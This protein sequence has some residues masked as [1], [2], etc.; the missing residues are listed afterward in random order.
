MRTLLFVPADRPD[1]FEKALAS[2]ADA[3]IVDLED[4]V[5]PEAKAF[6]R[7]ELARWLHPGRRVLVRI[8]APG[9]DGF[10]ADL[11]ILK[12]PGVRGVVLP[13]AEHARDV[14][15]VAAS[16]AGVVLPL[17]ET[18]LGMRN[19][20]TIASIRGVDRLLF[21]T[22]DFQ[23]DMGMEGDDTELL[24]FRSRLVWISRLAGLP[25]PVDGVSLSVDSTEQLLSDTRR[26]RALGFG[27]K[28]CIH[29]RQVA[30]VNA[31][32]APSARSVEWARRVVAA[33]AH[34]GGAA[35]KLDGRMIDRPV[36]LRAH[37]VLEEVSKREA[38]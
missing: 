9:T 32:F 1:R 22:I 15:R 21:G 12:L 13:K 35:I 38:R 4:A 25:S 27:G 11:S 10:D 2:G 18:A 14:R 3:V 6:A 31:A 17:I 37:G 7:E 28:M 20:Y 26:A 19:A 33:A 36:L 30:V 16:T 29:P 34:A 23:L 5:A 8:N 24:F